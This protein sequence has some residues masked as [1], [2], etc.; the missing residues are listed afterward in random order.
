MKCEVFVKKV[1]DYDEEVIF[2]A[3]ETK[4][5][6]SV[7]TAKKLVIKPNWVR[8][9]HLERPDQ[10]DYVITHPILISA[11]I[12]KVLDLMPSGGRISI[13]DGPEFSS[14]FEKL[15]SYYPVQQWKERAIEKQICIEIID[16][17][18]EIWEDDGNVVIKRIKNKGDPRGSTQIDLAGELSEFW[19]HS[20][21]KKGYFGADSDIEETNQ[22]HNGFNNLYRVSRTAIECDVFINLPKL[23]THK[24][25]G[26]T[27]CLKNLVGINTYRNFLPHC[28]LGIKEEGGDQFSSSGTRQRVEGKLMPV[29]HQYI[30]TQTLLSKVFSPFMK[31]G[32]C[33]FGNNKVTI[34]GGSWFGNDTI[35]RMILDIN[36]ILMYGNPDGTLRSEAL[37]NRKNYIAVVDAI[38]CGEGNG[39]KIPEP[40]KLNYLIQG[41]NPV[42]VDIVC[43]E[44]MYFDYKR[45]PVIKQAFRI[46][47]YSLI[48]CDEKDIDVIFEDE[49][50]NIENIPKEKK[51]LF[52][53]SNGWL[54]NIEK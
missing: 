3:L 30:R 17:R 22:A 29:I 35:W 52:V 49:I 25:A 6:E 47:N 9:A 2:K 1:L 20:K 13:I 28:S 38:L 23:K 40:K 37:Q 34:R 19:G 33:I 24:K 41:C 10:W 51:S 31:L 50:Y 16:L 32:K 7:K 36:K 42:E 26:I 11:V 14:S 27:C 5:F 15:I 8:E 21:S 18:D 12:R 43:A 53:A 45:I 54:N 44:L 39:P 4:L 46:S 48:S